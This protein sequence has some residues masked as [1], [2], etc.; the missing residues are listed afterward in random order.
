MATQSQKGKAFEYATVKAINDYYV[1]S[2]GTCSISCDN[3][4]IV[5]RDNYDNKLITTEQIDYLAAATTG[6]NYILTLEPILADFSSDLEVRIA[7]DSLG[8]NG[9][10]R[11]VILSKP[12][13]NW[14]IGISCKHNHQALKHQRLSKSIDFGYSWAGYPVSQLYWNDIEPI[15]QSLEQFRMNRVNWRDLGQYN[16]DK[17][18]D[19]YTPLLTAFLNEFNRL[20][21]IHND[22]APK[23]M[24]YLAGRK[25][26]YKFEMQERSNEISIY[27]YNLR[28]DLGQSS[29]QLPV[30]AL[31]T[32]F[33]NKDWKVNRNGTI[34]DNTLIIE[35]DNNWTVGLRL[36]SAASLVETSLKFDSQPIELPQSLI[37]STYNY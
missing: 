36:H 21:A 29:N 34:S 8:I 18:R 16:F 11:D 17:V 22:L 20:D 14:E 23:F 4:F 3:A 31:P 10:V 25:D 35:M 13:C 9:D 12:T 27:S 30:V 26:F 15:F 24:E 7:D 19:V 2:G 6:L 32:T 37:V 28:G 5:A 1:N 33:I